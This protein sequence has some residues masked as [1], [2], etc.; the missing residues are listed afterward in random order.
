MFLGLDIGTSAVKAALVAADGTLVAEAA[1]PLSISRPQPLWSEQDPQD[2]W[3][4]TQTAVLSLDPKLRRQ[5]LAIGLT[6]QMHGAVLLNAERRV[7]RPAVLWNDGRSAAECAVLESLE[8]R[9]RE[10]T[11]NCAMP[12]FT[13]PKILWIRKRE[14]DIAKAIDLVLLPKD[15]IRLRMTGDAATDMSDAA[16]TLW[17][18]VAARRWSEAMLAATGLSFRHMPK[19]YE[20]VE[21]TGRLRDAVAADWGIDRV[22][23]A[24]GASDNAAGA[25]G[26]GVYRDGAAMMSLGTSGVT[27]VATNDHRANF[28]GGV[29]AFCHAVPNTWHQMSVML[30]AASCL[31][32]VASLSGYPTVAAMLDDAADVETDVL[33]LPYLSGERTPYN[34]AEAK[35]VFFGMTSGTD[36]RHLCRAVLEGVAMGMAD[37]VVALQ[38][39]GSAPHDISVIG[40]GARS[41][42][43][44]RIL[45][46]ALRTT[47]IYRDGA[48]VG[49]ALGAARL[50]HVAF[51]A[52]LDDVA[53]APP[54]T[55]RI[56]PGEPMT[57]KQTRFRALYSALK[58]EFRR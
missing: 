22:P 40:G 6:G 13:A 53:I 25:I 3:R 9:A 48:A 20:G 5:I 46:S 2:W 15:Y 21:F 12:G 38:A 23:V 14:P 7:L 58:Q 31:D 30:S 34:D 29:H 41:T 45:A 44:G 55:R 47:L 27:F 56:G 50:A 4:A 8:P 19:T 16:G 36:R 37:G 1:S 51:G 57:K 52:K 42:L 33:F 28:G 17:L 11:G 18:D 54:E 10:I 32:W 43:L 49:P 24:A 35:G 39:A 26:A